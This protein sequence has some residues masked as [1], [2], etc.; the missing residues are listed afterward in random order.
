MI[1]PHL[2]LIVKLLNSLPLTIDL[3]YTLR[4]STLFIKYA[5]HAYFLRLTSVDSALSIKIIAF[6]I[7]KMLSTLIGFAMIVSSIEFLD[8]FKRELLPGVL[9]LKVSN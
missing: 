7:K 9:I 4:T 3:L 8:Q 1:K 5:L 2:L 6:S